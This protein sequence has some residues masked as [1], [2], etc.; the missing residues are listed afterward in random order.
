MQHHRDL[1]AIGASAGGIE[2]LK[3]IFAK[4]PASLDATI[5]VVLHQSTQ[6]EGMLDRIFG[7]AGRLPAEYPKDGECMQRG[8]IY[9]APPDHHLVLEDSRVRTIK[10]P[11]ENR[12]RPAID[13]TFRSAAYAYG[14][15][16]IGVIL[17]GSLDDG[18]SG[19]MVIRS[20]GGEAIVQDP[21]TAMYPS[22][23]N[24]AL[25]RVPDAHVATLEQIPEL[26]VQLVSQRME[27]NVVAKPGVRYPNSRRSPYANQDDQLLRVEEDLRVGEPSSYACPE[28]G[29]VL[30]EIDQTGFLRYRCRIGHAYT[31]QYL[32]SE[33]R[34]AVE[35]ALWS[36]LRALEETASLHRRLADRAR[37]DQI[38]IATS[39]AE[40]AKEADTNAQI[41]REFLIKIGASLK[42][43]EAA[44]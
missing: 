19:L 14:R 28:C 31:A 37:A 38:P 30:W 1:I 26:L 18:T 36:A 9:I 13:P 5:L 27:G 8:R 41:L 16:V 29:G 6:S 40:R 39:F 21:T 44:A 34:F 3:Q 10:G 24:N 7:S 35:T 43:P 32:G 23:P 4:L 20:Q 17:S 22:M 12:H 42:L 2:A 11:H 15:R 25:S 33:Q